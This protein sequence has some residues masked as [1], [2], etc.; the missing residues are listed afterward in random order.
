MRP[1]AWFLDS[2][3]PGDD[4]LARRQVKEQR[5]PTCSMADYA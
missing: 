3:R 5:A 2:A 1:K 4:Y